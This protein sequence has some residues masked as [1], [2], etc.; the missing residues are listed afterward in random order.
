[1]TLSSESSQ[2]FFRYEYRY[3]RLTLC[4]VVLDCG[5]AVRRLLHLA[6]VRFALRGDAAG[7]KVLSCLV[8]IHAC[9]NHTLCKFN[10]SGSCNSK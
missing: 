4:L 8:E 1:M 7:W 6:A 10:Y 2:S 5:G 9:F 3:L